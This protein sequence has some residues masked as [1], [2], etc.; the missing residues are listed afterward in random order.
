MLIKERRNWVPGSPPAIGNAVE[1]A[2]SSGLASCKGTQYE[3][4]NHLRR[5]DDFHGIFHHRGVEVA[6]S[7][8][9][10]RY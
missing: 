9:L 1:E 8:K 10:I 4:T 7:R 2:I 3:T 6:D 5:G